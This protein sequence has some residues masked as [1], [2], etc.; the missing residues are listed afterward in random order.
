[1]LGGDGALRGTPARKADAGFLNPLAPGRQRFGAV[2]VVISRGPSC[3]PQAH[4]SPVTRVVWSEAV[5]L[6]LKT[7]PFKG[8]TRR[9]LRV[10]RLWMSVVTGD[11]NSLRPRPGSWG[12]WEASSGG[13]AALTSGYML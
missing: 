8:T 13:G 12:G 11:W 5:F 1:M 6:L 3:D 9:S 7:N 10:E 2:A 4:D